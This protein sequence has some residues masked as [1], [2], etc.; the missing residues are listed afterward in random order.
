MS[1]TPLLKIM[2]NHIVSTR[3]NSPMY[4]TLLRMAKEDNRTI[5][6]LIREILESNVS[7]VDNPHP[8]TDVDAVEKT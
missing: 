4:K 3:V 5:S 6:F 2:N 1:Y 8:P 7:T